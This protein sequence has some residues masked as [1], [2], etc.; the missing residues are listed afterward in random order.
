MAQFFK[1]KPNRSKQLSAR[2]SLQVNSLD[3]LGAGIAQHQGKVVFIPG[4]LPGETV[5]VQLTEQKRQYA[6]AKLLKVEQAAPCRTVPACPHYNACGGCDLQHMTVDAQRQAK[7]DALAN[8]LS[9]AWDREVSVDELIAG[10]PWHY[11]RRARLA[12]WYD[13]QS[14]TLQLGFRTEASKQVATIQSCPVL[15]QALSALIAPLDEMLNRLSGKSSL[16]HVEL[17]EVE[18]GRYL[19]LR[20]TRVP[21]EKDCALLAEFAAS[22]N[23]QILL[24]DN[25]G[26]SKD[27]QGAAVTPGYQLGELTLAFKPGNFIQVNGEINSAMVG[28][29]IDWLAPAPGERVLDLF[30]GVGNFSLPLAQTGAQVIGVEGVAEMVAQASSNALDAGLSQ[31]SFFHGDL[32]ADLSAEPWLGKID[33]LLLDPARAGAFESLQWLGK[34]KPSRIVYVSCNP[35]SLARDSMVLKQQGYQLAK[36]ALLDMFPQTHHIEAMA[37]FERC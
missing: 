31:V 8:M 27:L 19:V 10:E 20:V 15:A 28:R 18:S 24:V 11:R 3:H 37:L 23:V 5:T 36:L 1:V 6:K 9:R 12:T 2:L 30:C 35:A 16:G 29:A 21:G 33:K 25:E 13:R 4:V 14:K 7:T 32:S 17:I 22:H 26:H 34:M